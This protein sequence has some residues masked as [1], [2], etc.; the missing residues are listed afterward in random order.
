VVTGVQTCALPISDLVEKEGTIKTDLYIDVGKVRAEVKT[1]EGL[2]NDFKL[3]SPVSTAAVRGTIIEVSD[4]SIDLVQGSAM[5]YNSSNQPAS[6]SEGDSLEFDA[7]A[8]GPPSTEGDLL[9]YFDVD[10]SALLEQ[11]YGFDIGTGTTSV[12][13]YLDWGQ[14]GPVG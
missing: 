3:K 12:I 4:N 14:G 13:I 10:P 8:F 6:M 11:G 9:E 2:K 1:A 5:A 7:D